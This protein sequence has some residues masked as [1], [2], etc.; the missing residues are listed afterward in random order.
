MSN[1]GYLGFKDEN[2]LPY[3][4]KHINY[5][6]RVSAMPYLY[7]IAEDNVTGHTRWEKIGYASVP[8]TTEC[9]VWSA[10]NVGGANF[11]V[12]LIATQALMRILS[13]N[14]ADVGTVIRGD[15]TGDTVTSDAS[16]SLTVLTDADVDFTAGGT[17]PDIG[18]CV[19]L[20][21][22]GTTPEWGYVTAVG[23]H[24]LTCANG[25]SKLGMTGGRKYAVIDYYNSLAPTLVG[26]HAVYVSYLDNTYTPR[27]EIIVTNSGANGVLTI[28]ADYFR[29]NSLR[30]IATGTAGK[31]TGT[32]AIM[33]NATPPTIIYSYISAGFTRA[34]NSIYTVPA[35]KTLYITSWNLGFGAN[36][37][38]KNEYGRYYIRA[39]QYTAEDGLKQIRT[40]MTPG[41]VIWYPYS[42]VVTGNS[43]ANVNFDCPI[44][45][46][47][48]T[49]LKVSG[50]ASGAG[51]V[52]SGLKGWME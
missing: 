47:E 46:R 49:S 6:P 35:G 21:P 20:D 13:N 3:G 43:T 28:N 23:L 29:I 48:M 37:A 52:T 2:G 45:I 38:N 22:H 27:K 12:P 18:D 25:F 9:D 15:A 32:V 19:I 33:N 31:P 36:A 42:E 50:V 24:T 30:V 51:I 39:A 44:R 14:A 1:F 16:T 8:A 40:L 7:D 41:I 26:C 4:I 34:R 5:K 17:V 10:A 11:T